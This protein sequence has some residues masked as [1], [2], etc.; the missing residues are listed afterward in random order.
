MIPVSANVGWP[1]ICQA[2]RGMRGQCGC[3]GPSS[4]R[5]ELI[6]KPDARWVEWPIAGHYG[7]IAAG[8]RLR[9]TNHIEI[10]AANPVGDVQ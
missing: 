8:D 2:A 7:V 10:Y 4:L 1:A 6:W 9:R 5:F 3:L